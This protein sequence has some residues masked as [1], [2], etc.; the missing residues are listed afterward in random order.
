M[1][2]LRLISLFFVGLLLAGCASGSPQSGSGTAAP[3]GNETLSAADFAILIAQPDV[4]LLDVRTPAEFAS[5][6]LAGSRN[7]DFEASDFKTQISG[8]PKD[9]TYALYCRSGNRSGQAL[10]VMKAAGFTKVQHLGGG[11]TSWQ[12]AGRPVVS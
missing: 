1:A 3:G 7:V 12:A 2:L 6:H 4:V 5:G 11:I 8:L 10:A 9:A